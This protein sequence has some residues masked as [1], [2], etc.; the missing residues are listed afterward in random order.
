[1]PSGSKSTNSGLRRCNRKRDG[2]TKAG[3]SGSFVADHIN[4]LAR[5]KPRGCPKLAY[6]L[7]YSHQPSG[8]SSPACCL[9]QSALSFVFRSPFFCFLQ[10]GWLWQQKTAPGPRCTCPYTPTSLGPLLISPYNG[11]CPRFFYCYSSSESWS[12]T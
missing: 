2:R 11:Q 5:R 8:K 10:R 9:E 1:M 3:A 7:A 4:A 12:L 6:S